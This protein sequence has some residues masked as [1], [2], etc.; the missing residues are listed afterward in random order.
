M[1]NAK[2][3]SRQISGANGRKFDKEAVFLRALAKNGVLAGVG[4]DGAILRFGKIDSSADFK[5]DSRT[6]FKLDSGANFKAESRI[7][8]T[9]HQNP[10]S[11]IQNPKHIH[12]KKSTLAI[13]SDG[14]CEGVHFKREWLSLA[15]IAQKALLVNISDMIAMNARAKYALLSITLP[16]LA[17][18]EIVAIADA[19]STTAKKHGI[20][21]IGG[22]T[23]SAPYLSFHITLIGECAGKR[24]YKNGLYRKGL[25][26]GDLIY[27]TGKVG[28]AQYALKWLLNGGQIAESRRF[29][30]FI[31]PNL[32]GAFIARVASFLHAGLDVSDGVASELYRLSKIN[33]LRFVIADNRRKIAYNSGEEYEMLFGIAPRDKRRLLRIAKSMRIP[34]E[35]I[36]KAT[37]KSERSGAKLA[38]KIWHK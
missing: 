27:C 32:R 2:N 11:R 25:L 24:R 19:L 1:P 30:R 16:N 35:Y 22:D 10:E 34:L 37:Q 33:H 9:I 31:A 12:I 21:L 7:Q 15:Q 14:F 29:A 28:S 26:R 5:A 8:T 38:L 6:S 18:R 17:P 4:D 3:L 23:M 20:A 36:G 13:A